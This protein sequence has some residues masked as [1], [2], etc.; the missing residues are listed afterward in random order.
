MKDSWVNYPEF[1]SYSAYFLTTLNWSVK[2]DIC[3]NRYIRKKRKI[4]EHSIAT[5]TTTYCCP[6]MYRDCLFW[7]HGI[8]RMESLW[9]T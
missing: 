4:S 1:S 6:N 7:V 3:V 9:E 8:S 5:T 2:T